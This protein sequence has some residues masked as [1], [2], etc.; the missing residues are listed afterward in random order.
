MKNINVTN[1]NLFN[2]DDVV[3]VKSIKE[4]ATVSRVHAMGN[5]EFLY[6]RMC[7]NCIRAKVCHEECEFCDEF[8][9]E[10]DALDK[11]YPG[12]TFYEYF[13]LYKDGGCGFFLE[14]DLEPIELKEQILY[15][16]NEVYGKEYRLLAVHLDGFTH[17]LMYDSG[18]YTSKVIGE[19]YSSY[20]PELFGKT[21]NV[22]K[23]LGNIPHY[24]YQN[25]AK[26][27]LYVH[28]DE[29]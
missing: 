18:T 12:K 29:R 4:E 9:D 5:E 16:F 19:V 22:A 28:P 13:V 15:K 17:S 24:Q 11:E 25:N 1:K 23:V 3:L 20:A 7:S 8:E 27:I 21:S 14:E 10:L 26:E 6:G 2:K